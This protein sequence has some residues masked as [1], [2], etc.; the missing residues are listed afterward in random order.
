MLRNLGKLFM[1]SGSTMRQ[2]VLILLTDMVTVV[3]GVVVVPVLTLTTPGA[4]RTEQGSCLR[5]GPVSVPSL[6]LRTHTLTSMTARVCSGAGWRDSGSCLRA[7]PMFLLPVLAPP[8]L[9]GS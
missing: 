3:A 6:H 8:V 9:P 5:A 2:L 4:V 7:G 1:S